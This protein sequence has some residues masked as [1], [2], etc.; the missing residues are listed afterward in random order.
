MDFRCE[1][2]ISLINAKFINHPLPTK[3]LIRKSYPHVILNFLK[4]IY[5]IKKDMM[6]T[7]LK[8]RDFGYDIIA[9]KETEGNTRCFILNANKNEWLSKV[10]S[11]NSSKCFGFTNVFKSPQI[12]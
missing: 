8:I 6:L 2:I 4:V 11:K 7:S 9:E 1:D 3:D 10:L 5:I 12:Q